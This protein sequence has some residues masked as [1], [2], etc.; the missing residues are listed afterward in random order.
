M[1]IPVF[2]P[3][4]VK[5]YQ[6]NSTFLFF[7][8]IYVITTY[9]FVRYSWFVSLSSW[10]FCFIE[11]QDFRLMKNVIKATLRYCSRFSNLTCKY[12]TKF[13]SSTLFFSDCKVIKRA[14]FLTSAS[15]RMTSVFSCFYGFKNAS[16][17]TAVSHLC[18]PDTS[19]SS[20]LLGLLKHPVVSSMEPLQR[21][22]HEAS[23]M[24]SAHSGASC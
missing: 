18:R 4:L 11:V 23:L 14:L 3:F 8:R 20:S 19:A 6:R 22:A 9:F 5:I 12:T 2:L 1:L 7:L 16:L 17:K 15:Q 13:P 24:Q 21:Q 10:L